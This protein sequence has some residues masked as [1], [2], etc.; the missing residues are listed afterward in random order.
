MSHIQQTP[1]Q[2]EA[3]IARQRGELASTVAELQYRLD[4]K[5]RGREKLAELS[6]RPTFVAGFA[7]ALAAVVGLAV[8]RVRRH[9]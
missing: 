6:H 1:E 2:I 9:D 3:D 5:S 4:V 7:I 8:W